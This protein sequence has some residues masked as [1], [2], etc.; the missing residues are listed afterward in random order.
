ML[1][2]DV[3]Q[4]EL[5]PLGFH[6]HYMDG[7]EIRERVVT[8]AFSSQGFKMPSCIEFS[9]MWFPLNQK[10]FQWTTA[11]SRFTA[12]NVVNYMMLSEKLRRRKAW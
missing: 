12:A 3:V 6:Y 4:V 5:L 10:W 1:F 7:S 8:Q 2:I 9:Y 11:A